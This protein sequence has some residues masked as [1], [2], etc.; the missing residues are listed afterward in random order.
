MT[1]LDGTIEP[2]KRSAL[3]QGLTQRI[4]RLRS[5]A[6]RI[7]AS[8]YVVVGEGRRFRAIQRRRTRAASRIGFL[9]I[10]AALVFDAVTLTDFGLD[11][12]RISIALDAGL[13]W[14]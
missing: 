4:G 8:E 3:E 14:L 5:V 12:V 7:R 11:Q 13:F 9:V 2:G 10:A 6:A 1:S